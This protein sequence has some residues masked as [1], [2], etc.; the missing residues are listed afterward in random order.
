MVRNDR[1]Q[2]EWFL[3]GLRLR[4]YKTVQILKLTTF[5]EVLDQALW[6]EHGSAYARREH[7]SME[8]EKEKG[9][10]R[11]AGSVEGRSNAKSLPQYPRQQSRN[12]RPTRCVICNGDHRPPPCPHRDEKCFKC[13]QARH[14]IQECPSWT[15]SAQTTVSVQYA[16]QQ[17]EGLP[18]AM[19]VGYS[20]MPH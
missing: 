20:S 19:S 18:S 15:S 12:W 9:N 17:L 10:K 14:V 4:I 11:T 6:A 8:K 16:P 13:G 3:R 2:A 5:A 1:D 7:K